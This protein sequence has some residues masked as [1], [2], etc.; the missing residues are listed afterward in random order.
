MKNT[1]QTHP[2]ETV[3]TFV[4]R[5]IQ[6]EKSDYNIVELARL[7]IRYH[8]FPGARKIQQDLDRILQDWGLTEEE[9]FALSRD[10]HS[11]GNIYRR[12]RDGEE[13]QDWS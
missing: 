9:L 7:R 12:T 11:Q 6:E 4:I 1:D 8:N 10:I 2:R 3:D 13:Q 5:K